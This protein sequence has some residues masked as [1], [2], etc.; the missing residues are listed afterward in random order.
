MKK[1][2]FIII[3]LL[4]VYF[5]PKS[6]LTSPGYVIQEDYE[7]FNQTKKTCVGYSYFK[8]TGVADAPERSLCFGWLTK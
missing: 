1:I 8:N 6:Y 4:L 2:I 5:F 7:N 3:V